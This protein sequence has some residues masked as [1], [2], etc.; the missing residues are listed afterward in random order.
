MIIDS[1]DMLKNFT[2]V[3]AAVIEFAGLPEHSYKY[4]S[5]HEH[6]TGCDELETGRFV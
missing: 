5:S 1:S 3:V 2:H 6:K 4:D